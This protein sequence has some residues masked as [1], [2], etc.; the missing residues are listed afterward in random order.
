MRSQ[1]LLA[2]LYA[3]AGDPATQPTRGGAMAV[4]AFMTS[5]LS[6]LPKKAGHDGHPSAKWVLRGTVKADRAFM[7]SAIRIKL[8]ER[9][10]V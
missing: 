4:T 8:R 2:V 7:A 6:E 10:K 3:V 1:K 5:F 9:G